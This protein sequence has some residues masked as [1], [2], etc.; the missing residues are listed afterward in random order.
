MTLKKGDFVLLPPF[1][2][3]AVKLGEEEYLLFKESEILAL[4]E[5]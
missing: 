1:G 4:L 2:G 5:K 3:S